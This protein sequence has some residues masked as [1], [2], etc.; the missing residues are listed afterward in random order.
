MDYDLQ[1]ELSTCY[2]PR[3]MNKLNREFDTHV[4]NYNKAIQELSQPNSLQS[5]NVDTEMVEHCIYEY[6]RNMYDRY[7]NNKFDDTEEVDESKKSEYKKSEDTIIHCI[8]MADKYGKNKY[9]DGLAFASIWFVVIFPDKPVTIFKAD[10]LQN[11][12][13]VFNSTKDLFNYYIGSNI[14]SNDSLNNKSNENK[15]DIEALNAYDIHFRLLKKLTFDMVNYFS[16]QE[17]FKTVDDAKYACLSEYEEYTG[18]PDY[19]ADAKTDDE[20]ML[21]TVETITNTY[22]TDYRGMN[23]MLSSLFINSMN[24][25]VNDERLKQWI[26][27]DDNEIIIYK[28]TY[29]TTRMYDLRAFGSCII[30]SDKSHMFPY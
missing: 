28:N 10:D 11:K 9:V 13:I 14:G 21:K 24:K 17:Y 4:S 16:P 7:T 8:S 3:I 5:I 26:T 30:K 2:D 15:T 22:L 19:I 12:S 20:C 25:F 29:C 6:L 18:N 1:R 23:S 27:Y